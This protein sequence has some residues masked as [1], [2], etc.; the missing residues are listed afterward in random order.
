MCTL[1]VLHRCFEAAPLVVAA[2]RDEYLDRPTEG[3]ALRETARGDGR[4]VAPRDARAGGTWLGLN[5][6]GLFAAITNR[7]CESPD[8]DRRSRGLIVMDALSA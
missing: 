5:E 6:N 1:I 2:N 3:P 8:P 4:V 7:R